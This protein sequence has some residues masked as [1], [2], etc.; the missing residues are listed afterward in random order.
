MKH[1]IGFLI[2][3]L[4][5]ASSS[6]AQYY[7]RVVVIAR[8]D[9]GDTVYMASLPLLTVEARMPRDIRVSERKYSK[10]VN[11]VK[12]VYPYAKI[13]GLKFQEYEEQMA[14]VTSE[15]EQRALMKQA[16]E[17]LKAEFEDDIRSLT[18]RQGIILIKLVDRETGN[19]SYEVI[20]EL[21]GKFLAFF[22]QTIARLFGYDLKSRY[23][24][25][26]EDSE[27]EEIV[28]LIESGQL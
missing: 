8:I 4:G 1:I 6:S 17:E 11:H 14:L 26:G 19:S 9:Q 24:P 18:F 7:P 20:Q 25:E 12:K 15:Q 2:L 21:R 10:L 22:W 16:E 28:L 5:I 23:D 3:V 13:A 27:I